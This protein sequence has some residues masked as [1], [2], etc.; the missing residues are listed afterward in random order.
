MVQSR[1]VGAVTSRQAAASGFGW[2]CIAG[3]ALVAL[4]YLCA[5]V[6]GLRPL[7]Q[8]LNEPLLSL[9]P[10]FVFGFLIDTL[11]HAGKV[12]EELGLI[13]AMVVGLGAVGAAEALAELRWPWRYLPFAFAGACWLVVTAVLLPV[14]GQGLL[15]I[16]GGPATPIIWAALFAVYAVVLQMP[17]DRTGAVD[18]GRRRV[19]SAVPLTI[20]AVSAGVLGLRLL[21]DWYAAIFKA[22]ETGLK[23]A[24]PAITPVGNFYVVSKNFADPVVDGQAWSLKI[25]GLVSS[26]QALSLPELRALPATTE[27]VTLECVSNDV[28]GDLMSTGAFTGVSLRD[29]VATASPK[30]G[31]T[32][33]AFKARDGYTESLPLSLV[34]GAPEVLV[35]YDLDGAPL[36]PGH[37]Y[38]ARI[39]LP[40]HYGMKGPKWLDRIDLVDHE[41]GGYWE[42]QGWDHNALVKSTARFD[43]PRDGDIVKLGG[44][45]LAGVAFAG[46]RGV[47]KVEYSTDGGSTWRPAQVDAALSPYTWVLW[48]ATWIPS[49][50]GAYRLAV[51]ATDA[52]GEV[53][54][55]QAAPSYPNGASGY[56]SIGVNVAR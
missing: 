52:M 51:R 28:G 23:G 5:L 43:M 14:S 24:S 55:S 7:P 17:V 48:R 53:E 42:Q 26:P 35:A 56:H 27:Y 6:L 44:V 41:S 25:G 8:L 16:A 31:A 11:Q 33:V 38:P 2:G 19:L 45:S 54:T 47:S 32:W 30:A 4:M 3:L 39:V 29:L 46:N 15:G 49:G 12:V 1:V 10:G 40:G 13:V 50:E 34:A 37:G 36:P 18:T 22:P 20:A 21:P 9:M